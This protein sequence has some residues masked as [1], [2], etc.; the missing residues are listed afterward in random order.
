MTP[1]II[2]A[3]DLKEGCCVRLVQG[4]MA[5]STLYFKNPLDAIKHWIDQGANRL[6]I[7]DLDGAFAGKPQNLS[8]IEP[9]CAF[10]HNDSQEVAIEIGG[11]IRSQNAIQAYL[12]MGVH[13]VI[14][15]SRAIKEPEW[16]VDMI[17]LFQNRIILGLD[18][19]SNELATEGWVESSS[20]HSSMDL[21][22]FAQN[23][24]FPNQL[25]AIIYTDILQDGMLTGINWQN[26]LK[27]AQKIRTQVIAS[28]GLRDLKDVV[29]L[30]K[31]HQE[32]QNLIG[33]IAGKSL[34]E[35]TLQFNEALEFLRS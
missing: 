20:Q 4:D 13:Q 26:T 19:R 10:L 1:E 15:G 35:E 22:A 18:A 5:K 8:V 33:M 9:M 23:F 14:L 17:H 7:I 27:L 30:K 31:H 3:I 11:G 21:F 34:Y 24:D 2:P 28:G 25:F 12:D 16:F 32:Q 6:H 29:L